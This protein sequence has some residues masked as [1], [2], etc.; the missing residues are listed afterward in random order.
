MIC[1]RSKDSVPPLLSIV[2]L[3]SHKSKEHF[4]VAL[5]LS[6]MEEKSWAK[7]TQDVADDE[8]LSLAAASSK[9]I[10]IRLEALP[11]DYMQTE[12]RSEHIVQIAKERQVD[13]TFMYVDAKEFSAV[14]FS[15][16]TVADVAVKLETTLCI[17]YNR[18][19]ESAP[20]KI[21]FP[22]FPTPI[23]REALKLVHQMLELKETHVTILRFTL[24]ADETVDSTLAETIKGD[25]DVNYIVSKEVEDASRVILEESIKDYDLIVLGSP[26][27][28]SIANPL[29]VIPRDIAQN[30]KISVLLVSP[31]H[32]FVLTPAGKEKTVNPV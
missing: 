16:T 5:H 7:L 24:G 12:R 27:D 2:H 19:T 26:R 22:Y 1:L 14:N 31:L 15:S 21:L 9:L 30:A 8:V 20:S 6:E 32:E 13:Y 3:I 28:W 23:A 25:H 10:N 29:K 4:V 18:T 11:M 17:L